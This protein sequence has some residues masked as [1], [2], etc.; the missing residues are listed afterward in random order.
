[1]CVGRGGGGDLACN[2]VDYISE[3]SFLS[4]NSGVSAFSKGSPGDPASGPALH[5]KHRGIMS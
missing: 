2:C 5:N 4:P 1:M 3:R